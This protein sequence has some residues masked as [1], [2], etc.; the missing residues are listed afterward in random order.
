MG[1]SHLSKDSLKGES[2]IGV[3]PCTSQLSSSFLDGFLDNRGCSKK[4]TQETGHTMGERSDKENSSQDFPVLVV[5]TL[6]P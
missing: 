4:E 5:K 6:Q 3:F 1:L 2:S